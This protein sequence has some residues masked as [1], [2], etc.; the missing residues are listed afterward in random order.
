LAPSVS[1]A[2]GPPSEPVHRAERL[3]FEHRLW[4]RD[5]FRR[6]V[7]MVVAVA[8]ATLVVAVALPVTRHLSAAW[9]LEGL[10][11]AVLWEID[12]TNWRQGGATTVE[13]TALQRSNLNFNDADLTHVRELHRVVSLNLAENDRITNKG[14][15]ALRGLDLLTDLNL[16]RMDRYRNPHSGRVS[17]PLTDACLVHAQTLPRLEVLTLAGNLITDKGLSQIATMRTLKTLDL[18]ATEVTDAG[19]AYIEGMKG[20]ESVNLGATRV[21]KQAVTQLQVARP[22]LRIELDTEPMVEESVKLAR[23]K[24]P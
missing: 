8:L 15:A 17:V 16:E 14:L 7:I 5:V 20:L 24:T 23:E 10:S 19:L 21:T 1:P 13:L 9:W 22:D 12:E 2:A 4:R 11:G 6:R 3:V 18:E